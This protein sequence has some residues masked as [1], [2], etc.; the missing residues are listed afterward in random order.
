MLPFL[1]DYMTLVIVT[2]A[3]RSMFPMSNTSLV[4]LNPPLSDPCNQVPEYP[5]R[6][7]GAFGF[8]MEKHLKICGGKDERNRT[9]RSCYLLDENWSYSGSLLV[10]RAFSAQAWIPDAGWW[11][12]GGEDEYGNPL[13]STEFLEERSDSD[14]DFEM[15]PN[16]P[17]G[18]SRHC[19]LSLNGSEMI[20][21]GGSTDRRIFSSKVWTIDRSSGTHRWLEKA[22]MGE[23]RHSHSCFVFSK[24]VFVAGGAIGFDSDFGSDS[25]ESY[26]V[27]HNVWRTEESLPGP[28]MGGAAVFW[29][30]VPTLLGGSPSQ[31]MLQWL[32]GEWQ[33]IEEKEIPQEI[34][35][36][37]AIATRPAWLCR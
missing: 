8:I 22:E 5:V 11:V 32:E 1:S 2:G 13:D 36:P 19:L 28:T 6:L 25:V 17:M 14:D 21:I 29:R 20:L 10:K 24:R 9:Q 31:G 27:Y 16:L 3:N 26:D 12:T 23:P 4:H 34:Y 15:G 18:I 35:Y 37:V 30:G 7:R 33:K